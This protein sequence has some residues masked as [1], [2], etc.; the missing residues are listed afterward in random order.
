MLDIFSSDQPERPMI[1]THLWFNNWHIYNEMLLI[2]HHLMWCFCRI[3]LDIFYEIKK[4]PSIPTMLRIY[5]NT[6][7]FIHDIKCVFNPPVFVLVMCFYF[8]DFCSFIDIISSVTTLNSEH[9]FTEDIFRCS[10]FSP[11]LEWMH[12]FITGFYLFFYK[13]YS[14][15]RIMLAYSS[16]EAWC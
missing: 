7:K 11:L 2:L 15:F 1:L 8:M 13:I 9:I 10:I 14:C 4:I 3:F 6:I 5:I 12:A 16:H